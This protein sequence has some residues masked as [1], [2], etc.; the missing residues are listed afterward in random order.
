MRIHTILVTETAYVIWKMR[1][2]EVIREERINPRRATATLHS[3][4]FKRA[5]ID[6]R[7]GKLPENPL[8]RRPGYDRVIK[9]TWNGLVERIQGKLRWIP[10]DYG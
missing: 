9:A 1:N 2:E 10:N 4:L 7:A 3:S 5:E 8:L 6:L